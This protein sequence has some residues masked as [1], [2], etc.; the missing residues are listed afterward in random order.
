MSE[1]PAD[2]LPDI[3][4]GDRDREQ[5]VLHL[6]TAFGEG[7]LDL[8]E[9]DERLAAAYSAKTASDL[10]HLT[11]D[12]PLASRAHPAASAARP[13]PGSPD[14]EPRLAT[15]NQDSGWL[16]SAWLAYATVVSINLVVWLA[17]GLGKGFD[18]PYFWPMWVAGPWG[19]V[20]L[21]RTYGGRLSH[22]GR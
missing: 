18:F 6:G 2:S 17:L 15:R 21:V 4:I 14:A 8:A 10:L 11:A 20:L 22:P 19:V 9:Y 16:R 12:L 3:R 13:G 1:G 5:A 7:R